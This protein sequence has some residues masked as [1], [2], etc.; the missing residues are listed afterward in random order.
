MEEA[1]VVQDVGW[2]PNRFFLFRVWHYECSALYGSHNEPT[3]TLPSFDVFYRL[4]TAH[5]HYLIK[6]GNIL[7]NQNSRH[8]KGYL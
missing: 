2:S 8:E 3:V 5:S 6:K 1:V 7:M 4:R